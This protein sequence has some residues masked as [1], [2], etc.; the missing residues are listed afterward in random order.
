MEEKGQL[1]SPYFCMPCYPFSTQKNQGI[2]MHELYLDK[3]QHKQQQ[4]Y[5]CFSTSLKCVPELKTRASSIP[6]DST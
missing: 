2:I 4:Q 5:R 1:A 3:Q 6:N